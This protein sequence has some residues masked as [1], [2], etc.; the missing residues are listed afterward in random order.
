MDLNGDGFKDILSGSYSRR[1]RPMAGLFQVLWGQKDGSFKTAE[2]LAGTDGEP[3][4]IPAGEDSV[5]DAI[6]TRPTATDWDGDGD[7]D[8][9]VG[10][11]KGTFYVFTGEGKGRFN[12][13]C[14][15]LLDAAGEPL[16]IEAAHSD[17]FV[18]DFDGD[19]DLDIVSGSSRAGVQWSQNTAGKGKP[20]ALKPFTQLIA[21]PANHSRTL[22][23][24]PTGP[25]DSLRVWIDDINGDNK[26]DLLVGD[27]VTITTLPAG[28]TQ[29]QI[30]QK[31]AQWQNEYNS[32][33][34]AFQNAE[35]DERE[36]AMEHLRAVYDKRDEFIQEKRTGF[37]W[38]YLRK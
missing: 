33:L 7:L 21:P 6:C 11:F 14:T 4:V 3:L 29:E 13:K 5:T 1:E 19:G 28:V 17:P 27:R 26:L 31:K 32:A 35:P 9:V 37:V 12:P 24:E 10:N 22:S 16:K 36:K 23:E 2:A 38:L 18:I 34:Q 8:L 30:E 15:L 20:A 25:N